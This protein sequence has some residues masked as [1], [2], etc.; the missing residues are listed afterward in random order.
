[1]DGEGVMVGANGAKFGEKRRFG[2]MAVS[3][4]KGKEVEGREA[5][6]L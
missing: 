3:D 1:M 6:C 5:Y 4:K 2:K